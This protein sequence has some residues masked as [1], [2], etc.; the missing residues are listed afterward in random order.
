MTAEHVRAALALRWPDSEYLNIAEAPEQSDRGGRKLDLLVISLWRSRGLQR[1]GVEIKVSLSDWKRELAI[2]EKADWWWRHTHR[3]W[4]AVPAD[5]APKVQPD[6]PPTWGLLACT[7]GE[8]PKVAVKAQYHEAEPLEWSHCVG[9]MRAAADAGIQAL[10]RAERRGRDEGFRQGKEAAERGSPDGAAVRALEQLR[11]E[12]A[13]F[14]AASGLKIAG[15][16]GDHSKRLG[17]AVALVLK[18]WY[19][20]GSATSKMA[21][22]A[23]HTGERARDLAKEADRIE[24]FAAQLVDVISPAAVEI[25]Q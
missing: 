23:K 17:A 6:L 11:Q 15:E 3:F 22:I 2:G 13:D 19:D 8:S 24:R 1:D 16:W 14:E 4:L 9:L 10:G 18:E 25:P 20:P 12:V 5:L 21:R 7:I